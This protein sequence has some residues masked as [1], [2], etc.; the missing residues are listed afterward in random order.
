[1][2]LVNV[3]TNVPWSLVQLSAGS[4]VGRSRQRGPNISF[5][6]DRKGVLDRGGGDVTCRIQEMIMSRV[7]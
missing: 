2:I 3:D 5:I 1:M 6:L 4:G 7:P